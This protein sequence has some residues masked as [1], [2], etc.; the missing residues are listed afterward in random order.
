MPAAVRT[1]TACTLVEFHM[2][3]VR[4]L[5]NEDI[6][7]ARAFVHELEQRMADVYRAFS[8]A[9]FAS[10]RERIAA[11]LLDAA[12]PSAGGRPLARVRH[13]D[14][15]ESLGTAREVVGRGLKSLRTAGLITQRRG[16]IELHDVAGLI[17]ATGG[18]WS[19]ARQ[20]PYWS[21]S[22]ETGTEPSTPPVIGVDASGGMVV[23]ND[24]VERVF[25]WPSAQLVG[26]PVAQLVT[27]GQRTTFGAALAAVLAGGTPVPVGL[28]TAVSGRRRDGTD[29]AAEITL[30]RSTSSDRPFAYVTVIDVSYRAALRGLLEREPAK[31]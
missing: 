21:D 7:F 8:S 1:T 10:V 26:R 17:A 16:G 25:G 31:G 28:G 23:S 5:E 6:G 4:R 27:P 9:A 24:A 14:I 29:F 15:A 20:L 19:G 13:E 22:I 18:W 30:Q 12:E 3:T 11:D 2:A